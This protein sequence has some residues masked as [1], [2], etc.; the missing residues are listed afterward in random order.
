MSASLSNDEKTFGPMTLLVGCR[1]QGVELYRDETQFMVKQGV[2]TQVHTAYSR[3]P[4]RP[5]R[6]VQHVLREKANKVYEEIVEQRGH[7]YVCGDVSMAEDVNQ[8]LRCIIQEKGKLDLLAVDNEIKRLQE[9]NR[10]HEDIFG[11]TL[12]TAEVTSRGR[13]EAKNRK[14]TS[15]S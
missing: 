13:A 8:T 11:I 6:Y 15:S 4:G 7:F 1:H 14:S 3:I 10:Y 9:E 2:L 5:K 12:K